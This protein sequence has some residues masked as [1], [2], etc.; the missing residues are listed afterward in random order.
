MIARV[1]AAGRIGFGVALV[2]AAERVTSLWL[3]S[4]AGRPGARVVTRRLGARDPALGVRALAA[5]D[6]HP[7]PWAAAAIV[8]DTADL[9]METSRC[10]D[11]LRSRERRDQ[12]AV[13][14]GVAPV[15]V[16][17]G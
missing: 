13:H 10:R 11:W 8:A 9:T 5:P 2:V 4:D 14:A 17:D 15:V 6:S 16:E 1:A 7:Q 12:W 3:G